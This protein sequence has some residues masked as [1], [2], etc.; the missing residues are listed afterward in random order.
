[1]NIGVAVLGLLTAIAA[2]VVDDFAGDTFPFPPALILPA[3]PL[4]IYLSMGLWE[5]RRLAR[6]L[7]IAAY[8]V[9][10]LLDLLS[11]L[12]MMADVFSF[13]W[14]I[15]FAVAILYLFKPSVHQAFEPYLF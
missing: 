14:D 6:Y 9:L 2:F 15:G 7:A 1:V 12:D 11:Q 8:S 4:L 10:I 3:V 13:V 5:M